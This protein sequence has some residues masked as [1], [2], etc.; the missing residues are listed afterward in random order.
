VRHRD[1]HRRPA[2]TATTSRDELVLAGAGRYVEYGSSFSA[3]RRFGFAR[4]LNDTIYNLNGEHLPPE[5]LTVFEQLDDGGIRT[6]GHDVPGHPRPP[7]APG[8]ARLPLSRW[9]P[10]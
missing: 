4:Q 2:G 1:R 5:V 3:S 8:R 9:P 6:A 7:R 10:P